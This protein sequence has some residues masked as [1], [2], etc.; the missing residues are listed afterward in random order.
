MPKG[1]D[2]V[3]EL[4]GSRSIHHVSYLL[5]NRLGL[6]CSRFSTRQDTWTRKLDANFKALE[7]NY[8]AEWAEFARDLAKE[9]PESIRVPFDTLANAAFPEHDGVALPHEL[10]ETDQKRIHIP[11]SIHRECKRFLRL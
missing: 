1:T 11:T 7:T 4:P 3:I 5:Q 8:A 6:F 10:S 9:L 2:S